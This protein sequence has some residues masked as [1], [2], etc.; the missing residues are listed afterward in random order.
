MTRR[1]RFLPIACLLALACVLPARAQTKVG[2]TA[3]PF[4]EVGVGARSVAMG[5]ASAALASDVSALYW[6]PAGAARLTASEVA[7]EY[8]QWFAGTQLQYAA[9]AVPAG[10]GT[11]G[12]HAYV[13]DS[14][15]MEETTLLE[16][17][18][19]GRRFDVQSLAL[20]VSYA[21]MLTERFSVGG[22][23]KYV[24]ENVAEMRASAVALDLGIQYALPFRG[25]R[26]GFAIQN[27]GPEMRLDGSD[28]AVR[29]DIDPNTTGDPDATIGNLR[30]RSW[31]LPLIFRLG[32]AYNVVQ[33]QSHA[34]TLTSDARYPNNNDQ[35]A[36]VGVEYGFADVF[37]VRAGAADLFTSEARGE[38]HLR[39]GAGL[40]I[41]N[42]VRA[43]YAWADRGD[44]GTV[45][46]V[47]VGLMF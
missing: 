18:G 1:I 39:L 6:N 38:S 7:F 11:V 21:R 36:S 22:T 25:M 43:D 27:F 28:T 32:L 42:R 33:T 47:G 29:V 41:A 35:S 8:T 9:A 26:L 2:T 4:L 30:T 24:G 3:A 45:N 20:G 44:L 15:E 5:E 14:G 34:L 40:K 31:D 46:R 12:L 13:F 16:E 23:V 10:G 19:N 17:F 37:F